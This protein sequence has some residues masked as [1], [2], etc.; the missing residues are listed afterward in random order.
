M[1]Q[2]KTGHPE[3]LGVQL[4]VQANQLVEVPCEGREIPDALRWNTS[5]CWLKQI[6][7]S[8]G[9]LMGLALGSCWGPSHYNEPP[10]ALGMHP[11]A[12]LRGKVRAA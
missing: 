12:I 5:F 9:W 7:V 3:Q 4:I 1:C 10:P 2:P 6:V 8:R 11:A